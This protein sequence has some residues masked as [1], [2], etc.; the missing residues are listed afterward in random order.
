[1]IKQVD[2]VVTTLHEEFGELFQAALEWPRKGDG[3]YR[4]ELA[5]VLEILCYRC[6]FDGCQYGLTGRVLPVLKP[7]QVATTMRALVEP[8][9]QTC[10][11]EHQHESCRGL[12]AKK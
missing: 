5:R 12:V 8:L 3:W 1:M 11:G 10:R 2:G 6:V 9:S 7:W 4:G